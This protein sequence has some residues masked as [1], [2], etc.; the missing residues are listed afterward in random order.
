M[1]ELPSGTAKITY[2]SGTT[3]EPK[4]VCLSQAGLSW[5]AETLARQMHSL[6]LKR[7]LV[8]LPLCTLLEN[9]CGIYIPLCLGVETVILPPIMI[10]FEGSSQFNPVR[11][12]EALAAWQPHSLVLVPE[13]IR[14]LYQVHQHQPASTSS[15]RFVAAGGGKISPV[16]LALAQQQGLPVYE[17][18]GL[19]ECGSVVTLNLPGEEKTGSVGKP[20]PGIRLVLDSEGQLEVQ[21]PANALGYLNGAL[22]DGDVQTGDIARLDDEGFLHITGRRKN[23]Q[24][25]AF[26]RNFSPEWIEAEAMICPAVRRLVIFGEGMASNVALVD[27]MPGMEQA[28]R[29]QLNS[30]SQRL[31]DYAR[32][33]HLFFTAVISSPEALTPNGRPR[34]DAI[35]TLLHQQILRY[36]EAS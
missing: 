28:A 36:S 5:S 16:L 14:V 27:A 11:F 32:L 25:T 9:L 31:P 20:L 8:T 19:S 1:P 17:G 4:G 15:L 29:E 33:H 13:L 2:T 3:G 12:S 6:Q 26:G 21:S 7:H 34:R 30:L 22:P 35:W 23:V 24:I 18:Y 10:G